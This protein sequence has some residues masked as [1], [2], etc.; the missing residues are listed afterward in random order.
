MT[1]I[2]SWTYN[3]LGKAC[4]C[5]GG[6][7]LLSRFWGQTQGKLKSPRTRSLGNSTANPETASNSSGRGVAR[8]QGGWYNSNN[9]TNPVSETGPHSQKHGDH[10]PWRQ[11]KALWWSLPLY[12]PWCQILNPAGHIS[13]RGTLETSLGD[14]RQASMLLFNKVLNG[15][16]LVVDWHGIQP[17]QPKLCTTKGMLSR[18]REWAWGPRTHH[19]Y[20]TLGASS[21]SFVFPSQLVFCFVFIISTVFSLKVLF[22]ICSFQVLS[23]FSINWNKRGF[24]LL[25]IRMRDTESLLPCKFILFTYLFTDQTY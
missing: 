9:P 4:G 15:G 24:S 23:L 19:W 25:P 7:E 6:Y 1:I 18:N 8:Q 5:H 10:S 13:E 14:A 21:P 17:Q 12:F 2:P 20:W 11:K 16:N 22:Y 3:N